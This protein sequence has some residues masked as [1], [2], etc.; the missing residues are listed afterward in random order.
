MLSTQ[1]G[2]RNEK[3]D[4]FRRSGR[5]PLLRRDGVSVLILLKLRVARDLDRR[6][7]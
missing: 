7:S 2:I 5:H 3:R 1:N 4:L 6:R